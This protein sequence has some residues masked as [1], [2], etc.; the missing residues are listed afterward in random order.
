[1]FEVVYAAETNHEC[2]AYTLALQM[3]L[4]MHPRYKRGREG[5]IPQHS[6][7]PTTCFATCELC[8]L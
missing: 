5:A 2:T 6:Q 3:L 8:N 4:Q 1:M 7:A